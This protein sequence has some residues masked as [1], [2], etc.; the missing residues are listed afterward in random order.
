MGAYS[1][2]AH[3]GIGS[4]S[5]ICVTDVLLIARASDISSRPR[6]L[7]KIW[8]IRGDVAMM[9]QESD[10][11]HGLARLIAAAERFSSE[12]KMNLN[13]LAEAAV[14]ASVRRAGWRYRP[15]VTVDSMQAELEASLQVLRQDG[16]SPE[17]MTALETGLK[18]LVGDRQDDLLIEEAPDVF[19]CRTCGY[20]ALGSAPD[21]CP[22]CGAWPGRFRK[23]VAF[24]NG[25]N[26]EPTDPTEVLDLL[27]RNADALSA[28]VGDLSEDVTSRKPADD[29]WSIHEHVAH[30]YDTQEL[31]D[32]RIDLMLTQDN[33]ELAAV[34]V[35]E[36]ATKPDRHQTSTQAILSAFHDRRVSCVA[37]LKS[38]PLKDWWHP[39]WHPEFGRLTIL[40][41]AAYMAQHEQTHFPDIEALRKQF[42]ERS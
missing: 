7:R 34:A 33:P 13:K 23:F 21:H 5:G 29:I 9:T 8:S 2:T 15:L 10:L 26:F 14:Y 32:T 11:L 17:L 40:R 16:L 37:R 19:V 36:F 30:F 22:D 4:K 39:G 38:L 35:Y 3:Q 20:A 41:Q 28:L 24:F 18:T 6:P 12:G 25:D 42:G 31:L 27:A 1:R